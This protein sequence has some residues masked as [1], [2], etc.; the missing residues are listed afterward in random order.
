MELGLK[1]QSSENSRNCGIFGQKEQIETA[2]DRLKVLK[3][4]VSELRLQCEDLKR[5]QSSKMHSAKLCSKCSQQ[6]ELGQKVTLK[7]S[8]GNVMG[9][10]HKDCFK[11]IWLSQSWKFDYSYPGFL[12]PSEHQR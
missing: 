10:Y 4:Q 9:L 2:L 5:K 8:L 6:V 1:M 7:D 12:R 3:R 11:T